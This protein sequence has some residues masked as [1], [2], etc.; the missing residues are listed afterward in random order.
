VIEED[1]PEEEIQTENLTTDKVDKGQG[2]EEM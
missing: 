1:L 2:L